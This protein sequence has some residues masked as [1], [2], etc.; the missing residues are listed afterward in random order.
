MKS[1]SLETL[2]SLCKRRGFIYQ[3]SELYGG[4]AG[5]WDYGPLGTALK[6]NI[7]NLWWETFVEDTDNVFGLD[8]TIIMNQR[9]WK[10]SGH[11]ETFADPIIEDQVNKKQYR[12]DHL[13]KDN[14]V[15]PDGLT[16][17]QMQ[18]VLEKKDIKSPDGNKL[19]N[20]SNFNLIPNSQAR[21][22]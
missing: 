9:V 3:G 20:I 22:H 21:N 12:L 5:T 8:S 17:K 6:R 1:V 18:E 19:G 7:T 10:A 14:G 13:L 2:A 11:S 16:I 15:D 4:M